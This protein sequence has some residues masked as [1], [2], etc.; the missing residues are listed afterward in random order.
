MTHQ[1]AYQD[2]E[3]VTPDFARQIVL[4]YI[5]VLDEC[6]ESLLPLDGEGAAAVLDSGL[7]NRT[8]DFELHFIQSCYL[9]QAELL[10]NSVE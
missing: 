2:V 5:L 10:I 4:R 1:N 7:G 6:D 9:L 3:E 8:G